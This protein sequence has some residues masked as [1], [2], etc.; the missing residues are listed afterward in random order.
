M[1]AMPG[2]AAAQTVF[3]VNTNVDLGGGSPDGTCDALAS[4]AGDQCTLREAIVEANGAAN[5]NG[6]DVIE[7]DIGGTA[8]PSSPHVISVDNPLPEITQPVEID[9]TSS[10]E[11]TSLPVI[12][13]D[14]TNAGSGADAFSV[15]FDSGGSGELIL[16]GVSI[17]NFEGTA[18]L[19]GGGGRNQIRSCHIG[20]EPDGVTAG[21]NGR[22]LFLGS[23]TDDSIV[24]D[25][26]ISANAGGAISLISASRV[27]N[28]RIGVDIDGNDLGNQTGLSSAAV[29]LNTSGALIQGNIIA[30]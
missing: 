12:Q 3:T 30:Y 16:R 13:I 20:V 1:L 26:I 22:G 9:G 19:L 18:L 23:S 29:S 8:S 15:V 5:T 2:P 7:F 27:T 11:Y 25:N 10:P 17:T 21:G 6:P 28:N 24:S 4:T 14:G